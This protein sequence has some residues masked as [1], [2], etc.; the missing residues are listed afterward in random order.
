[1]NAIPIIMFFVFGFLSIVLLLI[2]IH[3]FIN[4]IIFKSLY[5]SSNK[6]FIQEC[7]EDGFSDE[8][9]KIMIECCERHIRKNRNNDNITK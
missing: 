9:I 4:R 3:K 1:M 6:K 7:K 2:C 8:D 5:K